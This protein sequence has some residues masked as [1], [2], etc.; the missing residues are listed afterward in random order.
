MWKWVSNLLY[1]SSSEKQLLLRNDQRHVGYSIGDKNEM[2][3]M[4]KMFDHLRRLV[5]SLRK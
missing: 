5:T 3:P 1:S 4:L 2:K